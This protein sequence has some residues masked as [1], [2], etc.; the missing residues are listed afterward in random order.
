[1]IKKSLFKK[2]TALALATC[3][4][5]SP[6]VI[7]AADDA[8]EVFVEEHETVD[9]DEASSDEGYAEEVFTE[10]VN[11]EENIEETV[12]DEVDFVGDDVTVEE[13]NEPV[14]VE[15]SFVEEQ[16]VTED[17]A[18]AEESFG[19]DD[20]TMQQLVAGAE[21]DEV[22]YEQ[23]PDDTDVI[24]EE[25][26]YASNTVTI[27]PGADPVT[28]SS[29]FGSTYD[30]YNWSYAGD[31]KSTF[32]PTTGNGISVAAN[33]NDFNISALVYATASKNTASLKFTYSKD[34]GTPTT[35][36][37]SVTANYDVAKVEKSSS[38]YYYG[39]VVSALS[40]SASTEAKTTLLKDDATVTEPITITENKGTLNLGSYTLSNKSDVTLAT[41]IDVSTGGSLTI[42]GTGK[43]TNSNTNGV[44]VSE[45][46]GSLKASTAFLSNTVKI[47]D[48][49][50]WIGNATD[51]TLA[52]FVDFCASETFS[53][54]STVKLYSDVVLNTA[55]SVGDTTQLDLNGHTISNKGYTTTLISLADNADLT[56]VDS[57]TSGGGKIANTNPDG[58]AID[59][60]LGA[61]ATLTLGSNTSKAF[62]ISSVKNA[63]SDLNTTFDTSTLTVNTGATITSSGATAINGVDIV[64]INAGTITGSTDGIVMPAKNSLTIEGGTISPSVVIGVAGS[65]LNTATEIKDGTISKISVLGTTFAGAVK[66]SDSSLVSKTTVDLTEAGCLWVKGSLN[67]Y[68]ELMAI[69]SYKDANQNGG[70]VVTLANDIE[71]TDQLN[72][73]KEVTLDLNGKKLENTEKIAILVSEGALTV[74]DSK[75][76]GSIVASAA[77][78]NGIN[79]TGTSKLIVGASGK[80]D[81]TISGTANGITIQTNSSGTVTIEGGKFVGNYK[82][83]RITVCT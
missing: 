23:L 12:S 1:M 70:D 17:V 79:V 29:L 55:A 68:T 9:Q 52:D 34:G 16:S 46:D 20:T 3:L 32:T 2:I 39:S 11:E 26:S 45:T 8:V 36:T 14:F 6:A 15:D 44:A 41:I 53:D 82:R 47:A 10:D 73:S 66:L 75:G 18:A 30:S 4:A 62:T 31:A 74:Y 60:A 19:V 40:A 38:T 64:T 27:V 49:M 65:E 43:I 42:T 69:G 63:I 33:G 28:L 80:S 22:I 83:M 24:S 25:V 51:T 35:Y 37:V 58:R 50:A 48:N 76:K 57:A 77:L 54:Y 78:K 13:N 21:N 7:Y 5:T 56:I 67:S 61:T 71:T 72:I 81:F 59:Y